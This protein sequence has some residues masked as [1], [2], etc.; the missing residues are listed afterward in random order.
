MEISYG[1][2]YI[3]K[4]VNQI[5]IFP[6]MYGE[7]KKVNFKYTALRYINIISKWSKH[8]SNVKPPLSK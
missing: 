5:K 2:Y 3:F 7:E 8:V 4:H 1:F 6:Y